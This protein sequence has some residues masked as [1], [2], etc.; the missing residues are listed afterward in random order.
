MGGRLGASPAPHGYLLEGQTYCG[1]GK[2]LQPH[3]RVAGE[4][5]ISLE[6]EPPSLSLLSPPGCCTSL[7]N[8]KACSAQDPAAPATAASPPLHHHQLHA[9]HP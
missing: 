9:G 2:N 8:C 4:L 5:R 7:G 6:S 1:L 3:W